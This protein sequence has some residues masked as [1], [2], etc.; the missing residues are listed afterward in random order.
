MRLEYNWPKIYQLLSDAQIAFNDPHF[1]DYEIYNANALTEFM[2]T[3]YAED[4]FWTLTEDSKIEAQMKLEAL[5]RGFRRED[6][7]PDTSDA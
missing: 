7:E 6:F 5:G 3:K 2:L 4:I 1:G